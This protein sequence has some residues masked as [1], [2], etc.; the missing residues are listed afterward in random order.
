M[1]R[2][3]FQ[4]LVAK[5]REP[6]I[7]PRSTET[8][9]PDD[10]ADASVKRTASAPYSWIASR[11]SMTLPRVF[12]I[13]SPPTRTSPCRCTTANG[14]CPV[15][16]RPAMIIRATQKKRMSYPVTRTSVG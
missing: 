10:A 1:K 8:V 9:G 3:V 5:F 4:T 2:A 13:F 16:R 12:D 14:A 6:V 11:G 15:K 7:R